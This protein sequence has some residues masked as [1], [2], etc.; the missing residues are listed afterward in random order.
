MAMTK[1]ERYSQEIQ[2]TKYNK[3]R[4]SLPKTCWLC[5]HFDI[6]EPKTECLHNPNYKN[7]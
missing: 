3:W 5:R 1:K 2:N 6:C 4:N 7:L